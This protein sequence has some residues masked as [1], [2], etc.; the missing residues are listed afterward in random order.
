MSLHGRHVVGV[1]ESCIKRHVTREQQHFVAFTSGANGKGQLGVEALVHR[2]VLKKA[3]VRPEPCS[4]R[5]LVL[6]I[7]GPE[8]ESDSDRCSCAT[9]RFK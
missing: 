7:D 3:R 5:L 6:K 1:Q 8:H 2:S 9:K 4:P